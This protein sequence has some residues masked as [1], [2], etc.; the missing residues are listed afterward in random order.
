MAQEVTRRHLAA[1]A[2]IRTRVS[3]CG[4][5]MTHECFG[6]QIQYKQF[7]SLATVFTDN[8]SIINYFPAVPTWKELWLIPQVTFCTVAF[9]GNF[10]CYFTE[11]T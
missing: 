6:R 11:L 2:R 8:L 9:N 1:E 3:P 5:M 10:F 7:S 4:I